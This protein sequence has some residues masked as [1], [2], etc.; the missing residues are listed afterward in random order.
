MKSHHR[1]LSCR[2]KSTVYSANISWAPALCRSLSPGAECGLAPSPRRSGPE[3]TRSGRVQPAGCEGV[4]GTGPSPR[5]LVWGLLGGGGIERDSS[6]D[7]EGVASG[8]GRGVV[9]GPNPTSQ[10]LFEHLGLALRI[11]KGHP[12]RERTRACLRT[13]PRDRA[14]LRWSHPGSRFRRGPQSAHS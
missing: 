9:P 5:S 6:R 2:E 4:S 14:T 11:P 10:V 1:R 3:G 7:W 8:A 13:A 12:A